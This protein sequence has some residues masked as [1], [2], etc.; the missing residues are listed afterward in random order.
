MLRTITSTVYD[1]FSYI[2]VDDLERPWTHQK[3]L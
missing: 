2:N 1:L 3:G